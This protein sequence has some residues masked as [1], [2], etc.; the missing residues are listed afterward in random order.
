MSILH[1]KI[2]LQ[3]SLASNVPPCGKRYLIAIVKTLYI[4]YLTLFIAM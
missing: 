1:P 2:L 4:H 3:V